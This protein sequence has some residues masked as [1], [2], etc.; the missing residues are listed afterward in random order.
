MPVKINP[1]HCCVPGASTMLQTLGT[2]SA[3]W[4]P[5]PSFS[6]PCF[7]LLPASF[8]PA[9]FLSEVWYSRVLDPK[10]FSPLLFLFHLLSPGPQVFLSHTGVT[11]RFRE[12]TVFGK[13]LWVMWALKLWKHWV[14]LVLSTKNSFLSTYLSWVCHGSMKV[15]DEFSFII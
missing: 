8:F 5:N 15:F 10:P 3:I 13:S 9:P 14:H 4:L 11:Q 12:R 1:R 7:F 6:F 2:I